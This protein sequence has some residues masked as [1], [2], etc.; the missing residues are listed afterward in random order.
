MCSFWQFFIRI[1]V[2]TVKSGIK[3]VESNLLSCS[4]TFILEF[5]VGE[6]SDRFLNQAFTVFEN[7]FC[8]ILAIFLC[9]GYLKL[10][11]KIVW[12]LTQLLLQVFVLWLEQFDSLSK[13]LD[14]KPHVGRL[15]I[16]R[17]NILLGKFIRVR[18]GLVGFSYPDQVLTLRQFPG[19]YLV[20]DLDL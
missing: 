6:E 13:F 12:I 10:L 8:F 18:L 7:A 2:G 14:C 16:S 4:V 11:W 9:K 5:R 20:L 17:I 3:D 1:F 19:N 15:F